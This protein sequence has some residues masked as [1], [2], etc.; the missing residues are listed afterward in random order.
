MDADPDAEG[1]LFV[2]GTPIGNLQDITLRALAVL[3]DADLILA[4]DTR[5][6]RKLLAHHA[7]PGKL[8]ALHA[9]SSAAALEQCLRELQ[10]GKRVAL[11]TDAGT[12]LVSDPGA[13]LVAAART[14]GVRVESVPG[15]SALTAALSVCGV[16]F[17]AFRFAGFAPRSGAKRA[18]W[19][20]RIASDPGASVFFESPLRLAGTLADLAA[21][22]HP[23]RMLAVCRELTKLHEEVTRGTASELAERFA[24][25][26]RGEITVV[27]GAGEPGAQRRAS[28][29]PQDIAP[30]AAALLA[31]GL[32]ARDVARRLAQETGL[33]RRQIYARVQALAQ[34][35]SHDARER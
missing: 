10:S 3:R 27:V 20:E 18:A 31:E 25:G 4:E 5:Q 12:P 1:L 34:G 24:A 9:H 22:L 33:P 2:I 21:R 13:R 29:A 19:L 32:S 6:S 26:A 28:P 15:P 30:R 7:I 35:T 17:D 14:R 23:A 8:R 11:I 16:P